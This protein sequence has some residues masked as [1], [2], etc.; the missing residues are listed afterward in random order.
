M[1]IKYIHHGEPKVIPLT[2][3]KPAGKRVAVR[4]DGQNFYAPLVASDADNASPLSITFD[5]GTYSLAAG[6]AETFGPLTF[7][8]LV[9]GVNVTF[10]RSDPTLATAVTVLG[11]AADFGVQ[12]DDSPQ[13]AEIYGVVSITATQNNS[14]IVGNA[15]SNYITLV[16]GK[17]NFVVGGLKSDSIYWA[18]GGVIADF[19]TNQA[20]SGANV[21]LAASVKQQQTS[22]R[23]AYERYDAGSYRPGFTCL[24]VDGTITGIYRDNTSS[25]AIAKKIPTDDI[26]I[27]YSDGDNDHVI[28]CPNIIKRASTTHPTTKSSR[29]YGSYASITSAAMLLF[30]DTSGTASLTAAEKESI[31]HDFSALPT[32]LRSNVIALYNMYNASGYYNSRVDD[33]AKHQIFPDWVPTIQ[34][35]SS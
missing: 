7:P 24:Y 2:D 9:E 4:H 3:T 13:G 17:R 1:K 31:S 22:S 21:S 34:G 5:G 35:G 12:V 10:N 28:V 19:G 23:Y 33:G 8:E 29:V 30:D 16:G 18:G 27:T 25:T 11:N 6:S 20:R 14:S 26:W 15:S 32:S